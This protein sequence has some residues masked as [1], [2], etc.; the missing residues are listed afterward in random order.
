MISTPQPLPLD[1]PHWQTLHGGYRAKFDAS[2]PLRTLIDSGSTPELWATLWD[3]LH[4]QGDVD[5]ASYAAV[6]WLAIYTA[7][8]PRI[9]WDPLA[10]IA[11]IELCRP[12]N[13]QIAPML[14]DCYLQ[15]VA[16]LPRQVANHADQQWDEGVTRCVATCMALAKGHRWFAKACFE[17]DRETADRWFTAEFGWRLGEA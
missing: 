2:I 12:A 17:L 6:P 1:D 3:E 10:L 11:T 5:Q 4:H 8:Q 9:E 16:S 13:P 15:T 7:Q 14:E